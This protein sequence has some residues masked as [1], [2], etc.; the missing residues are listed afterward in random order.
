MPSSASLIR[1]DLPVKSLTLSF[2]FSINP[3]KA[4]IESLGF[5][6]K[7]LIPAFTVPNKADGNNFN[8]VICIGISCNSPA[9]PDL[10]FSFVL[11]F[12]AVY[13]INSENLPSLAKFIRSLTPVKS[14]ALS[15]PLPN[16][17]LIVFPKPFSLTL[18]IAFLTPSLAL[19]IIPALDLPCLY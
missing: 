17:S 15:T 6:I 12:F 8:L 3:L 7:F 13:L 9:I 1:S 5:F 14:L 11:L 19:V 16:A 2:P 18:S 4:S 10:S